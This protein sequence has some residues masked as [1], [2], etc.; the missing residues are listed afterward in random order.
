VKLGDTGKI[1][2][3][4]SRLWGIQIAFQPTEFRQA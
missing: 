3:G 1:G 2:G 4:V